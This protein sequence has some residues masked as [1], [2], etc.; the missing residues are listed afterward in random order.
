MTAVQPR[1]RPARLTTRLA[2][3]VVTVALVTGVGLAVTPSASY[4]ACRSSAC[5]GEPPGTHG[6]H[7]GT[8]RTTN[9]QWEGRMSISLRRNVDEC[10]GLPHWARLI[11]DGN[12]PNPPVRFNFRVEHQIRHI[13]PFETV[14]TTLNT[15]TQTTNGEAGA[16]NT[17]MVAGPADA[18]ARY[19]VCERSAIESI[20]GWGPWSSLWCSEWF[21]SNI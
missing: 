7:P 17:R 13:L 6:C 21:Y 15:E 20:D 10:G 18:G 16:W 12:H 5:N 19:R 2:T 3:L 9:F 1:T 11:W 14:W 4:A 8:A